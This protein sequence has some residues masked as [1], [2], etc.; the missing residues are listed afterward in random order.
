MK[1]WRIAAGAQ[2]EGLKLVD[3]KPQAL[4]PHDVRMRPLAA[5]LNFRDLMIINGWYPLV[6]K[7]PI[8]PGSDAAGEVTETGPAVTRFKVGDRVA[9]SFF[10]DWTEGRAT[11]AKLS[12]A[13][14]GGSNGVLTQDLVLN[15]NALV[16][17]PAHLDFAQA[18]T[19][20]C[21]GVTAWNALFVGGQVKP[22]DTVVLLGTG[23]VS[24]WALLLAKAAGCRVIITSS[25]DE[26]LA[27][28]R[29]LGAD[30]TINYKNQPD[31]DNDVLRLTDGVGADLVVE[32]GGSKTV[33]K[34]IS[35]SR[36]GGTVAI[37]GAVSGPGAAVEPMSLIASSTRLQGIY[38]GSRQMHEDLARFVEVAGIRPVVDSVF[39]FEELP[40]AYRHFGSGKHFGKVVVSINP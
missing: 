38:V 16:R 32:V 12:T 27:R 24:I 7:E 25:S 21:A 4:G 10:P 28:A 13:L 31:W 22:G 3:E 14:G 39:A 8:I 5:S 34:S 26:K 17:S 1:A 11:R 9:T 20:S 6:G 19:L 15:E 36:L 30:D 18:S 37:I 29:S 33:M 23:G 35:C 40:Q 2:L